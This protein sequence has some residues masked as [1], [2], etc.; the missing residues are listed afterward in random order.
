MI[1]HMCGV[2]KLNFCF[3]PS[4]IT[5][6]FDIIAQPMDLSTVMKKIDDR[7]Y[8]IPKQ[9]IMDVDLIAKNALE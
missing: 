9:W 8:T 7:R 4:Q 6:Y 5:D 1:K 2:N 3:Y